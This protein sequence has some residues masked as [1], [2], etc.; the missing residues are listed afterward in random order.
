MSEAMAA[1]SPS[2]PSWIRVRLR[3]TPDGSF[4]RTRD[5]VRR[6]R[7]GTVCEEAACPNI[8]ECWA[9]GHATVMIL[10]DTCTRACAFCNVKTGRPRAVDGDEPRRLAEAIS[11]LALSHVVV[12]SVDRD[13]LGDGGALHFARCIAAI[14]RASPGTTV[15]VLTPDFRHKEGALETV[16]AARPDVFNHNV[17]TVPR[18]YRR[19]RPGAS[20]A[21][22][23]DLLRRAKELEPALF[24]KSGM[25]VGLGEERGEV[26]RVMDDLRAADVDFLT[27]GQYLRPTPKHAA[28]ARYWTPGEFD[29][30]RR[31]AEARG[32][33]LV[34]S[35]PLTR[36]SHHADR[37]FEERRRRRAAAG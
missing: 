24:S 37:D 21:H 3:A 14:R 36:S 15:E 16:L 12:T 7:L 25:M 5:V 31:E 29:D 17:E 6:T 8:G 35:S 27:I 23:L 11:E 28:I 4:A 18:L 33:G 13:D 19:I 1:G 34:A 26:L 32:F 10:G 30:L 9:N 2:R 22:S 20:Y